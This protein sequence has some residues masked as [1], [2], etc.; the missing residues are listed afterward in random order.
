MSFDLFFYTSSDDED[1]VNSELAF[2]YG[3]RTDCTGRVGLL[4][5]H[6][7]YF[8]ISSNGIRRIS[9]NDAT[10]ARDSLVAFCSFD[11][12]TPYHLC[13]CSLRSNRK[14]VVMGLHPSSNRPMIWRLC[15]YGDFNEVRTKLERY[16]GSNEEILSNRSLLW[17]ELNDINS[18][19]SLKVA[20]KSKVRWAIEGD[21]NTKFFHAILN[22][23]RS[24]LAAHGTL[25]D[26]EWIVD[27]LSLEQ[28]VNLERNVSN[29]EIK[30]A[31]WD[32]RTNKSPG[33]DGFTFE[34]FP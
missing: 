34:F 8:R 25:V 3:D 32:C 21:E 28:Q 5:I 4:P 18:I 1:E 16:G 30:S 10:T 22:S 33:P 20:Q 9:A 24:Q 14:E 11:F 6:E 15:D 19:D 12:Q 29:E 2:F 17:K 13:L 7:V 23:K 26:G 31:V 27:L